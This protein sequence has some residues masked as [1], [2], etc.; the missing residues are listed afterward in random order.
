DYE[1]S[2]KFNEQH[3]PDS[4]YLVPVVAAVRHD[5]TPPPARPQGPRPASWAGLGRAG[6]GRG[7]RESGLKVNHPASFAVRLNG[8]QGKMEAKFAVRFIPRE[9]G[10]HHVHVTFNH[11]HIPGSP[12][13]VR[14]GDPGQTG[15]PGLVSAYGTGLEKGTTGSQ[16]EFIINNR[17]AG[18]G[19][20][21]VTIEGPSKVKMDCQ[22]VPEGYRVLYTPMAPGNYLISIKYGGPNHIKDSPFRARVSGS[23][24]V[25]VSNAS[26]TSTLTVDPVVQ[27]SSSPWQTSGP[28]QPLSDAGKVLSRGP[29]LSK[30][31]AGQKSSFSVDC[32]KAGQNMLMVGVRGPQVP[33]EELLVR[34]VGGGQYNVSYLLKERGGYLLAVKW[35][36]DH[37]PGSPFRVTVP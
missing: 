20:L 31:F 5:K 29:G 10:V 9:N 14:V 37:I 7:P 23:R 25:H 13:T 27:A 2:V 33:C 11:T 35:G 16:S 12:F 18:P 8:A 26:E 21:A 36:D 28:S 19:A 4:P 32:S 24:L 15:E 17:A 22:E 34:H 6:P 1:V 30:A 3:I